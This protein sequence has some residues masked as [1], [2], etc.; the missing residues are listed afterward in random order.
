[1]SRKHQRI[2]TGLAAQVVFDQ[3]AAAKG[4]LVK[5]NDL[6]ADTGLTPGNVRKG[7]DLIREKSADVEGVMFISRLGRHGGVALTT[8]AEDAS[9]YT[10]ARARIAAVQLDKVLTGTIKPMV[11]TATEAQHNRAEMVSVHLGRVIEDLDR[12]AIVR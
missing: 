10:R 2:D 4:D 6:A 5:V 11:A 3:L 7:L 12:L 1:M 9:A 8:S